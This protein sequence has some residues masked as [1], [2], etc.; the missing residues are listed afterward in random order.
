M[1]TRHVI[2]EADLQDVADEPRSLP[3][4]ARWHRFDSGQP[5]PDV[6]AAIHRSRRE[7]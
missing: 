5:V 2:A 1:G 7:H 4:P 6:V 3:M